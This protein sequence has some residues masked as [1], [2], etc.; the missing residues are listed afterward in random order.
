MLK[1]YAINNYNI[2]FIGIM[3]NALIMLKIIPT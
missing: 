3:L 2:N 1:F